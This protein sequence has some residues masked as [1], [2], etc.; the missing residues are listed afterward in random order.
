MAISRR[1]R[2]RF[3]RRVNLFVVL[4]VIAAAVGIMVYRNA[5]S[6]AQPAPSGERYRLG[7]KDGGDARLVAFQPLPAMDG[8]MCEFGP[9]SAA[10]SRFAEMSQQQQSAS[11]L[12][13]L[14]P[15]QQSAPRAA[16]RPSDAISKRPA[17]RVMRDP[18]AAFSGVAIDLKHNEVVLTDENNFAIMTYDRMENTPPRARMSEP[19]RIIQGMEAFLEFNCSVYVDPESGDIYSVNNDT[20]DWLTVFN[21]D[22]KATCRRPESSG[23]HTQ[24]SASRW[25]KKGR[26]CF[27]PSRTI[28]PWSSSRRGPKMRILLFECSRGVRHS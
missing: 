7:L 8:T 21:R 11:L 18:S 25:M 19:K 1:Q 12:A 2:F 6:F 9:A 17:A 3:R 23:R 5:D 16:P 26:R 13:L 20:L 27:W 28:M 24:P 15:Q 14:S 10:S 22:V 4:A